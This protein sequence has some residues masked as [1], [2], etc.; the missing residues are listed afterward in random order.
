M[1]SRIRYT[2]TC[3]YRAS[4]AFGRGSCFTDSGA[5]SASSMP[6]PGFLAVRHLR[7]ALFIV[8]AQ[9]REA[10]AGNPV[11]VAS[12]IT[13]LD[14]LRESASR[15]GTL[16]FLFAFV[17]ALSISRHSDSELELLIRRFVHRADPGPGT[18][19]LSCTVC[20]AGAAYMHASAPAIC[21]RMCCYVNP[22]VR[23]IVH[24][25]S[26]IVHRTSCIGLAATTREGRAYITVHHARRIDDAD[27][28]VTRAL[29]PVVRLNKI[30][31]IIAFARLPPNSE[32]PATASAPC[33]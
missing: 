9:S 2:V 17:F 6:S 26:C 4:A 12:T 7:G 23:V 33:I 16:V 11:T 15:V 30:V 18:G 3:V 5:P 27:S 20:S 1:C 21:A 24:H 31:H 10:T 25:A 13:K 8:T 32:F 29:G 28:S 19:V 22:T 14:V